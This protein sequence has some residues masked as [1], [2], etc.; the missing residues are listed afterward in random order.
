M[1]LRPI[2]GQPGNSSIISRVK[3]RQ[4]TIQLGKR[5]GFDESYESC[6]NF[7][8]IVALSMEQRFHCA[9]CSNHLQLCSLIYGQIFW[10][11]VFVCITEHVWPDIVTS[12]WFQQQE[13]IWYCNSIQAKQGFISS[14]IS[15]S[16]KNRFVYDVKANKIKFSWIWSIRIWLCLSMYLLT[17]TALVNFYQKLHVSKMSKKLLYELQ[18]HQTVCTARDK[19]TALKTSE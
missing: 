18:G 10:R 2:V 7:M 8:V 4:T 19:L 3:L 1:R 14:V 17:E 16:V 12:S 5:A 15:Q 6:V 9:L 11:V 13:G